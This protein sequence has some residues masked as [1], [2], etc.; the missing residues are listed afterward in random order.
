MKQNKI[1]EVAAIIV[2]GMVA[3][4]VVSSIGKVIVGGVKTHQYNRKIKKGLKEGTIVEINGLY[5]EVR[6]EVRIDETEEEA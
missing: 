1:V 6:I 2:I 3:I 5:Y 4:P